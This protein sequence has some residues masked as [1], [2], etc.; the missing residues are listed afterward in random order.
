MVLGEKRLEGRELG[1]GWTRQ[2]SECV[3]TT[4]YRPRSYLKCM[5]GWVALCGVAGRVS[6]CGDGGGGLRESVNELSRFLPR[7]AS[8]A[9]RTEC[10]EH[11]E[12]THTPAVDGLKKN[13]ARHPGSAWCRP[14]D[15]H[16]APPLLCGPSGSSRVTCVFGACGVGL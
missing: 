11:M 10:G 15:T 6:L 14:T 3:H 12:L 1:W 4:K 16:T 13:P 2:E 5:D 7:P 8:R 9:R